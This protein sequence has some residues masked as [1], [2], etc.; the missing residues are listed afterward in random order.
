M[1]DNGRKMLHLVGRNGTSESGFPRRSGNYFNIGRVTSKSTWNLLVS[2]D[3]KEKGIRILLNYGHTAAHGLESATNYEVFLHGE[4]VSIGM[5]V[6]AKISQKSGLLNKES[7][8]RQKNILRE[9]GLPVEYT[10]I[11]INSIIQSMKL[12]KKV[13]NKA[14][15]WVLLGDIGKGIVNN[16]VDDA[17]VIESLN[18][19]IRS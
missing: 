15:Q 8:R 5:M 13:R 17:F 14:V 19:V 16:K 10:G 11:S 9:F 3:E 2:E 6:A 7:V 12:D 4:A 1:Y 18:E